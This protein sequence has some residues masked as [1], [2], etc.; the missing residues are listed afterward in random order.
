MVML[1]WRKS[2]YFVVAQHVTSSIFF[3][4]NVCVE[5]LV[6]TVKDGWSTTGFPRG[7]E[8]QNWFSRPCTTGFPRGIEE[9]LN[10]KIGFQDLEV[11]I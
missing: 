5:F 1:I 2:L 9:V 4:E 8:Y 6:V 10:I 7:I 11:L 3:P